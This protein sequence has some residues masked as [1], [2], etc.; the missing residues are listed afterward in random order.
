MGKCWWHTTFQGPGTLI[1]PR[2][3]KSRPGTDGRR[4][5]ACHRQTEYHA[6]HV[7]IE[8]CRVP[9]SRLKAVHRASNRV[10]TS[11]WRGRVTAYHGQSEYH[12][13][14][15]PV[16][17]CRVSLKRLEAVHRA[18]KPRTHELPL[19]GQLCGGGQ[20]CLPGLHERETSLHHQDKERHHA[21]AA[22]FGSSGE[23]RPC[24]ARR[25]G[26]LCNG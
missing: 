12:A 10:K 2:D 23:T 13:L 24:P 1:N 26:L 22:P 5:T 3:G 11:Y 9:L 16:E 17:R 25:A 19:P 6:L 14:H 15:V 18:S 4:V 8:R 20:L 21:G 7:P